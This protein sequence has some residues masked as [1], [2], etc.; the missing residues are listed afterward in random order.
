M[1]FIHFYKFLFGVYEYFACLDI[2]TPP[3]CLTPMEDKRRYWIRWELQ[4]QLLAALGTLGLE[5]V[6][7]GKTVRALNQSHL[8]SPLKFYS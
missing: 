6:S 8:S 2:C 1:C 4:V 5:P 3:V 7:S